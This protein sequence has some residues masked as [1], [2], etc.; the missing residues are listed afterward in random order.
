MSITHRVL[1]V[2][3]EEMIRESL[4]EILADSGYEPV[5]AVDGRDALAKLKAGD[6]RPC[7]ILLDLMMPGMDGWSFRE[8]QREDPELA[9]IPVIVLSAHP[10]LAANARDLDVAD[11][12]AKPLRVATL[13][14]RVRHHCPLAA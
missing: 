6:P 14:E 7:V 5:P 12:L 2:D 4:V 10:D 3:D 11:Y 13:L 1:V 9:P 8:Q